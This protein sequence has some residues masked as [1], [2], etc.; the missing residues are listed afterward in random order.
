MVRWLGGRG[1]LEVMRAG[2]PTCFSS[3]GAPSEI[4][5][6][7]VS[8]G[9]RRLVAGCHAVEGTALATPLPVLLKLVIGGPAQPL[10]RW[11]R[12]KAPGPE[13]LGRICGPLA[14]AVDNLGARFA[15]DEWRAVVGGPAVS[16][17]QMDQAWAAWVSQAAGEVRE[18][19][20]AE[21]EFLGEAYK[22]QV[23]ARPRLRS[24]SGGVTEG[25]LRPSPCTSGET[26]PSGPAGTLGAW[27]GRLGMV[28]RL[29][30][31]CLSLLTLGTGTLPSLPRRGCGWRPCSRST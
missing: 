2:T 8:P 25:L 12:P 5:Y 18:A 11:I 26:G 15:G 17:E 14:Q 30:T 31:S 19:T 9:L 20:G 3:G 28:C 6:F 7:L 16:R 27:S 24:C 1:T 10:T 4:D 22:F 13:V 23:A 29:G 21:A